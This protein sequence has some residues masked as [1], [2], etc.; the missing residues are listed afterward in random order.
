MPGAE[1]TA[2]VEDMATLLEAPCV[3][4]DVDFNLLEFAAQGDVDQVR[5][6]TILRRRSTPEIRD[7]FV[8]H[9]IRSAEQPIRTPADEQLR[10]SPRLCIPA[11]HLGRVHGY[12]WVIDPGERIGEE[13]WPQAM[14]IAGAAGLMLSQAGRRQ[15]RI[16]THLADLLA[17]D[18]VSARRAATELGLL[19]GIDAEEPV[20]CVLLA[21]P[22]QALDAAARRARPGVLWTRSS[23]SAAVVVAR[24][25]VVRDCERVA[26]LLARLTTARPVAGG[27]GASAWAVCGVGDEVAGLHELG[28]SWSAARVALRVASRA[29][30]SAASEAAT[31]GA[32]REDAAERPVRWDDLGPLRLL[33]ALHPD[34]VRHAVLPGRLGAFVRD[35]DP[36]LVRT[37]AAYLRNAG[38]AAR[39]AAELTIHRQ[40][41]YHRLRQVERQTGTDL[42]DGEDRLALHL[43]LTLAPYVAD[44]QDR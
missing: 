31:H 23:P 25:G 30:S 14:T 5:Q 10:I 3:L 9:G 7:W 24:A 6:E 19:T 42:T 44:D 29:A 43:A 18:S 35:G 8:Q 27:A 1:L 4:E 20:V 36:V 13:L 12:F 15:A 16:E 21:A 34:D 38:S 2:V 32:G 22:E 40:S 28:R 26:D 33:E 11:R 37:A 17:G 41:L 39:T